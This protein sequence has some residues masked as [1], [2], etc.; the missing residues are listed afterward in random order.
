MIAVD[1][2]DIHQY[3][4]H[5]RDS[6]CFFLFGPI[7][8]YLV[9]A[10]KACGG[11][12]RTRVGAKNYAAAVMTLVS[13]GSK[14]VAGWLANFG[15]IASTMYSKAFRYFGKPGTTQRATGRSRGSA[16]SPVRSANNQFF[17]RNSS[18]TSFPE[19]LISSSFQP[20][21][22]LAPGRRAAEVSVRSATDHVHQLN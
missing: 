10:W 15:C 19:S 14:D 11:C 8:G 17:A 5:T 12:N 13:V 6:G 7:G 3:A 9:K 21:S 2:F 4:I 20:P 1:A 16:S 18:R 22:V